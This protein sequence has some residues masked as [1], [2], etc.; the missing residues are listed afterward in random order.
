MTLA[1]TPCILFTGELDTLINFT[2][3]QSISRQ[4]ET[5][6]KAVKEMLISNCAQVCIFFFLLLSIF[7]VIILRMAKS[8]HKFF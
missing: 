4:M 6:P 5:N 3:K 1:L 7:Y 8:W 2:A